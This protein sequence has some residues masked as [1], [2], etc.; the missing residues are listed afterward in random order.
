MR[1][2]ET[3][4]YSKFELHE[5]NRDITTKG[6]RFKALLD[7]MKKHGWLDAY[8]LHVV[9]NGNGKLKIK[10]G[11]RR[12][13]AAQML[14]ISVKFVIIEGDG[15]SLPE[16]ESGV[17]PWNLKAHMKAYATQ[18]N[19]NYIKLEEYIKKY[20]IPANTAI[21]LLKKDGKFGVY[22]DDFKSGNFVV[23]NPS[24]AEIVG[25][26]VLYADEIGIPFC[27]NSRFVWA[28]SRVINVDGVNIDELKI[29]MK[30]HAYLMSKQAEVCG[31]IQMFEKVYNRQRSNKIAIAI[32][33]M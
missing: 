8:P 24:H 4:D 6:K 22:I 17:E 12:F 30:N 27:R 1:I 9:R 31:Y 13:T 33:A 32:N 19:Q 11:H 3:R 16:L 29:K 10:G 28:I 20:G 21:T 2:R 14:G 26:I 25:E 18:G 5:F 23:G 7:S 15:S